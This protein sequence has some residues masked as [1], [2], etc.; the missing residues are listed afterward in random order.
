MRVTNFARLLWYLGSGLRRLGWDPRKL[1]D[2]QEKRLRCVVKDAY[3]T[4]AFYHERFRQAGISPGDVRTFE[5]LSKLPIITKDEFKKQDRRDLISKNYDPEK[6]K[7]VKTSG[8]SGQPFQ[9]YLNAAEDDWRKA[10]YMRANISCG[11]KARDRWLVITSPGHFK[12]TTSIQRR[13][14]IFAQT[15]V[16]VFANVSEQVEA[17]AKTDPDIVDGYSGSVLLLAKE[18][19][20]QQIETVKPRIVF[21]TAE[22][23]E[24]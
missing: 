17:A 4:S 12:D 20:R 8:S 6:L 19:K 16:S 10:I 13:M 24:A 7:V 14:G 15:C 2:Y 22:L 1:R 21:G 9:V 5:D 11:Q 23:I 3:A 18:V